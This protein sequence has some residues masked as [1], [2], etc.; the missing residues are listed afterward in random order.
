[1]LGESRYAR[2]GLILT[3]I[4]RTKL[5]FLSYRCP[6]TQSNLASGLEQLQTTSANFIPVKHKNCFIA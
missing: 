5:I 1:L 3:I 4:S 2:K 6:Q